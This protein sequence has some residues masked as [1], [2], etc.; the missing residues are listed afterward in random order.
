VA[1]GENVCARVYRNKASAITALS[2]C[3]QKSI[4]KETVELEIE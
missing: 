2:R 4:Q 3:C 1:L